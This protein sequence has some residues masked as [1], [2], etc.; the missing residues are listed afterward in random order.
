MISTTTTHAEVLRLAGN[1][2]PPYTDQRLS[3]GGLSVEL[4][5]TALGRAGYQVDYIEVPWA[6]AVLGLKRGNY[7]MLNVWPSTHHTV[8]ARY[9]RAFLTN[10]VRWVQ[11][12][13]NRIIYRGLE[14]LVPYRI[15]LLRGYAFS[16][17]LENDARL[18]KGYAASFVQAAR[19]LTAGRVDLTLEDERTVQFHFARELKEVSDAYRFVPGE[20]SLLDL[21]LVVRNDHPQQAAIIAAFDREIAAMVEDGSYAAIFHRHGLPAPEALPQP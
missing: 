15:A 18:N 19:M 7:D 10:R 14:S 17:A 12:H 11:R 13:D 4:V 16:E 6:R 8:Y 2:W 1:V 21:S 5:R 3:G 20:F 9:T